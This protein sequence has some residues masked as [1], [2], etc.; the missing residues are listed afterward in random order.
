[1]ASLIV[2]NG[3]REG[4][5]YPLGRR[6]NVVGRDEALPIQIL[7]NMVSRKHL[8][9]RFDPSVDKYYAYDMKSRNGVYVNNR[10]IEGETALKDGDVILIGLTSLLFTDKDFTDK[11]SALLHYKKV[12]ERMRVT[13]YGPREFDQ[14]PVGPGETGHPVER[15]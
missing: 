2:T 5:Y 9:I 4:D 12:G 11:E 7:D 15:R 6:T 1:M 14:T 3:K 13:T 10:K 8:Q